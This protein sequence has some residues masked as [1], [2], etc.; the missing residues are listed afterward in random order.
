MTLDS[1][2]IKVYVNIRGG[3]QYLCK[4]SLDLR[5]PACAQILYRIRV[6][7]AVLVFKFT[8]LIDNTSLPIGLPP[9]VEYRRDQRRCGKRSR[10]LWSAEYLESAE[11]LRIFC[12]RYIVGIL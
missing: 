3:S 12:R 4:F 11:K 9:V 8:S 10:G 7:Y 1:G 5:M 6:W 2:N